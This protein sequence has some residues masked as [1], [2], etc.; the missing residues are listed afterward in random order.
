MTR[1]EDKTSSQV[2]RAD[3]YVAEKEF[4]SRVFRTDPNNKTELKNKL[5]LN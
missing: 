4:G 1:R 2:L 5:K 3:L